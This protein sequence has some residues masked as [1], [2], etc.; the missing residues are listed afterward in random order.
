MKVWLASFMLGQAAL[1][2][3]STGLSTLTPIALKV[4]AGISA[5]EPASPVL[6][7]CAC[8]AYAQSVRTARDT[9]LDIT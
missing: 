1:A 9:L 3:S 2:I 7:P 4:S 5:A 8:R 6:L